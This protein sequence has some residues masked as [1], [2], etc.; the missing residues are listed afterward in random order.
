MQEGAGHVWEKGGCQGA[1]DHGSFPRGQDWDPG[2]S[3]SHLHFP[4][5][6]CLE[7]LL[8]DLTQTVP[9]VLYLV[10]T[11]ERGQHSGNMHTQGRKAERLQLSTVK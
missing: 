6:Q 4:G 7:S 8:Q 2:C 5:S 9:N 10:V 1:I 11:G 3:V